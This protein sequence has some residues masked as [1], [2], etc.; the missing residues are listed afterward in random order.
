M[1][2]VQLG[3]GVI[4]GD[5]ISVNSRDGERFLSKLSPDSKF[6]TLLLKRVKRKFLLGSFSTRQTNLS[7]AIIKYIDQAYIL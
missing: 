6:F 1:D 5:E 7:Q 4:W 3:E 2:D